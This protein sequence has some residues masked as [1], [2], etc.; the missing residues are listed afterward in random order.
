MDLRTAHPDQPWLWRA[1]WAAGEIHSSPKAKTIFL[2]LVAILWN[3]CAIS[4]LA[5]LRTNVDPERA[6]ISAWLMLFPLIG[7][8]V[9]FIA[10]RALLRWRVYGESTFQLK[11]V[12]GTIGGALEGVIRCSHRLPPMRTVKLHLS[13]IND[14]RGADGE[15]ADL[16]FGAISSKRLPMA[17]A[18][19]RSPSTFHPDAVRPRPSLSTIA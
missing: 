13:C 17:P 14:T 3:F 19:F 18:L 5:G 6:K 2:V 8:G 4:A 9:L 15:I 10:M 1:D 12:P 11:L 7:L 16:P